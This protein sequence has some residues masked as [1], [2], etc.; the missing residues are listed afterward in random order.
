MKISLVIL[1]YIAGEVNFKDSLSPHLRHSRFPQVRP[2]VGNQVLSQAA[3]N[4]KEKLSPIESGDHLYIVLAKSKTCF[5]GLL[6]FNSQAFF[7]R[8][9]DFCTQ[10]NVFSVISIIG[11]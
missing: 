7:G 8:F 6:S 9:G 4:K 11:T 3:E 10:V 5:V 2:S 1:L